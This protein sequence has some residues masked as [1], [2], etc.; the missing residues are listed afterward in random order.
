MPPQ[1]LV[2]SNVVLGG[3]TTA[4]KSPL[5]PDRLVYHL[6]AV[7]G[8]S[9]RAQTLAGKLDVTAAEVTKTA[10]RV[11]TAGHYPLVLSS[12][13]GSDETYWYSDDVEPWPYG[14]QGDNVSVLY[15][16]D[17][18]QL[19]RFR[20]FIIGKI[21]GTEEERFIRATWANFRGAFT[22]IDQHL[23][24]YIGLRLGIEAALKTIA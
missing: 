6:E 23:G 8:K 2:C 18:D 1:D 11:I 20:E 3:S 12:R 17:A 10:V 24:H 4:S 9:R 16:S 5:K 19:S 21:E 13:F 22:T 14:E 7:K 15:A